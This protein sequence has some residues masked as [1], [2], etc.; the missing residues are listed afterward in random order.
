[1]GSELDKRQNQ[2]APSSRGGA[3]K[4]V[5]GFL[6]KL[7]PLTKGDFANAAR[8]RK[9]RRKVFAPSMII[10]A[11]KA[12]HYTIGDTISFGFVVSRKVG[13][14][15][16][17]NLIKRRL[18]ALARELLPHETQPAWNYILIAHPSILYQKYDTLRQEFKQTLRKLLN[19]LDKEKT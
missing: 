3:L 19:K 10:H 12:H 15:W 11:Y 8:H 13:K 14:A 16:Q 17:R 6:P 7:Q 5:C 18:R 9:T 2:D 1:M 4:D